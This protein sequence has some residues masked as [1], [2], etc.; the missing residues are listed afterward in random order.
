MKKAMHFSY[1]F[2]HFIHFILKSGNKA[3]KHT[4]DT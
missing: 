2:I 3:H 4:Q 1:S